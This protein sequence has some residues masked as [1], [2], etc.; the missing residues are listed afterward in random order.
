MAVYLKPDVML[1]HFEN[2]IELGECSDDLVKDFQLIA[3][4]FMSTF[5]SKDEYM[6]NVCINYAVTEA[7]V[8]WNKYNSERSVNIFAFFTAM[9]SN[10]LKIHYNYMN[11]FRKTYVSID[12]F[13][14]TNESNK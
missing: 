10:D 1:K 12:L 5:N 13:S 6:K 4:N 9:I 8:K 3:E 2:S 11:R 7:W 14:E